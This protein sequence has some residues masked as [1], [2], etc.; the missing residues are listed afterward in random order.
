MQPPTFRFGSFELLPRSG[1]LRKQGMKIRLHGQPLEILALLLQRPGETVTRDELQKTLWPGDTFVDFE[2]GLNNAMNRLRAA[3][4]DDACNPHFIETLPRHGYRF[5]GTVQGPE[6][7]AASAATPTRGG[8]I[9]IWLAGFG[10]LVI[11]AVVAILAGLNGSAWRDRLFAHA[12]E[13]RIRSLA[14]LPLENLSG[15]PKQE[16]FADGI[17]EELIVEL[18]KVSAVRVISR[19]SIMQ[20]KGSKKS[21]Q[22]IAQEL[23][24][25][26]ALEGAVERSGDRVRVSLHLD[27]VSPE[28]Q[29]WANQYDRDIRDVLRLQDE[30]ART[31][32][33]E[34]QIDL[35]SQERASFA[36]ARSVDPE[37]HDDYLRGR[38]Q[39]TR[40]VAREAGR[41]VDPEAHDEY[42]QLAIGYFK[43]AIEKEPTYARPYAGLARAYIILG[44]PPLGVNSP[45]QILPAAKAAATRALELD[46]SLGEAHFSLAQIIELC[47]WNWSEAEKEYRT[48]LELN[49][50]SADSHLQY[51]RFLQAM[52]RN[53]ETMSQM[54]YAT[55]LDPFDMVTRVTVGFVT[56]ASRRYDPAIG[57]FEGLAAC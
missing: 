15:D 36:S 19:Q 54:K 42:V 27:Q 35:T 46:P 4:N 57:Q 11:V 5:I 28:S 38:Y 20:Y 21:L 47:D 3:L 8:R 32:T 37:A 45:K 49:P 52:G 1:E 48:A 6:R 22:E 12:A 41:S 55:E 23:N 56:Y 43:Q 2:Q 34:I 17:T 51:G 33:D 50:N 7:T 30:I 40:L 25:D 13:P 26:A 14:V 9:V 39:M 18:G 31:V 53:D 16:Y 24:V 29:L 44:S 10:A